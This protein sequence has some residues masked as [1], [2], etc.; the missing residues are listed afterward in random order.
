MKTVFLVLDLENKI[1]VDKFCVFAM[2]NFTNYEIVIAS[3]QNAK[4]VLRENVVQKFYDNTANDDSVIN[5][6]VASCDISNLVVIRDYNENDNSTILNVVKNSKHDQV[7]MVEKKTNKIK[8]FFQK[9]FA[10]IVFFLFGYN[11]YQAELSVAS[12][13]SSLVNILKTTFSPSLFTK[14]NKWVGVNVN[15]VSGTARKIKFKSKKLAK[16]IGLGVCCVVFLF[17]I[18]FWVLAPNLISSLPLK[19]FFVALILMSL[20]G[21]LFL[22]LILYTKTK[23]GDI[24]R[25]QAIEIKKGE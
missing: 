4:K 13:G 11:F 16:F 25:N 7:T 3:N 15:Y 10:R 12:F 14:I 1:N 9:I 19:L 6:Y 22:A 24:E 2:Q 8:S 23:I 20:V 18:L 5:S 21:G 17:G